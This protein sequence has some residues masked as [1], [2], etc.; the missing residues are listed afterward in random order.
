MQSEPSVTCALPYPKAPILHQRGSLPP[1]VTMTSTCGPQTLIRCATFL[2]I[3]AMTLPPQR[4]LALSRTMTRRSPLLPRLLSVQLH[5]PSPHL[6]HPVS[7]TVS[8][9]CR[10][11]TTRTPF[12]GLLK[13]SAILSPH[14]IKP[15]LVRCETPS[16]Q[17]S[18]LPSP[19]RKLLHPP[20]PS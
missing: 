5:R 3:F 10:R 9:P 13:A 19:H 20:H 12:A 17:V 16:P 18:W 7:T 11:L 4:F 2:V 15:L 14:Q 1:L 6:H 8:R